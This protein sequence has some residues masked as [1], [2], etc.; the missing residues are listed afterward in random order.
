MTDSYFRRMF[1]CIVA[2]VAILAGANAKNVSP[3][4]GMVCGVLP[5]IYYHWFYLTPMAKGGLSQV[6]I[7]SVYYFGF[8]ITITALGISAVS[9]AS[10]VANSG[11]PIDLGV[12]V[13]QFGAGLFA[14][15][16]AVIA[17]MHLSSIATTLA[18]TSP[19]AVFDKYM[20]RSLQLVDNV[21]MAVMRTADFSTQVVSATTTVLEA[22]RS[23]SERAMLDVARIFENEMKS[24]LAL[25]R[26]GLTEIRALVAE[27]SFTSEREELI[28][29]VTTTLDATTKLNI[30]LLEF[31]DSTNESDKAARQS[32][33]IMGLLNEALQKFYLNVEEIGGNNG[34]LSQH[35]AS[36]QSSTGAIEI[37]TNNLNDSTVKLSSISES[38]T[39]IAPTFH[40]IKLNAKRTHDQLD[41]LSA[42]VSKF[43]EALGTI[44]N[45]ASKTESMANELDRVATT[46]P[47]MAQSAEGLSAEMNA[48]AAASANFNKQV[49]EM[50][51]H[52]RT[53][54]V[55][56]TDVKNAL[57]EMVKSIEGAVGQSERLYDSMS[58]SKDTL[59]GANQVM[60]G[61][62]EFRA[63]VAILQNQLTGFG[64]SVSMIQEQLANSSKELKES[65][66]SSAEQLEADL[67]RSTAATALLT[68]R[69]IQ[70]AQT[71]IDQT[72][73]P[74]EVNR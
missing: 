24:S 8:L 36:I 71:V 66:S 35:A 4:V 49:A 19:D 23:A 48:M 57:N 56:G 47:K 12:V 50:P 26:E 69:L 21:E 46:M 70:V 51:T 40:K 39:N 6:A 67:K 45:T 43:E 55:A 32:I 65:I 58:K 64:Q 53:M 74:Q 22:A 63:T 61:A 59:V 17:R 38:L 5:L 33:S 68:D 30:A 11:S 72:R 29:S 41:A 15:G 25:T 62:G 10:A 37:S 27:S 18:D 7:D 34:I 44:A 31:S 28:K 54:E 2:S 13:Y 73:Q 52:V 60:T 42:V 20:Q 1:Y 16:Y 3:L 9:I 14:T